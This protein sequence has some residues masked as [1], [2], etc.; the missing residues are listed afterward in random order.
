MDQFGDDI[1]WFGH[2][3]LPYY[4]AHGVVTQFK[5]DFGGIS[6]NHPLHN[7]KSVL[8]LPT[9]WLSYGTIGDM[10]SVSGFYDIVFETGATQQY[11]AT[12]CSDW[13]NFVKRDYKN[14]TNAPGV[15]HIFQDIGTGNIY[16]Y[17]YD[18]YTHGLE[19]HGHAIENSYIRKLE[20]DVDDW[21]DEEDEPK[22]NTMLTHTPILPE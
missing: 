1:N 3:L 16:Q 11:R 9:G 20:W 7:A 22:L 15:R 18:E 8:G 14:G 12:F 13:E 19:V 2:H 17:N 21:D 5:S 6:E 4:D 10:V